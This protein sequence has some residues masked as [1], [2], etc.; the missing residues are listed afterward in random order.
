[1][2]PH[3]VHPPHP[4]G[5][6]HLPGSFPISCLHLP[7]HGSS[8]PDDGLRAGAEVLPLIHFPWIVGLSGR[9]ARFPPESW[10]QTDR[11]ETDLN[12]TNNYCESFNKTF[13]DVVDHSNPTTDREVSL[14]RGRR[15]G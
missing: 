10:D 15:D 8:Q 6:R 2:P 12:R 13:A 3:R 14:P 5:Q 7:I 11:V 9:R 4:Q 1:M